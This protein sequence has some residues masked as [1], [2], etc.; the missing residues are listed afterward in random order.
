MVS[1]KVPLTTVCWHEFSLTLHPDLYI[2]IYIWGQVKIGGPEQAPGPHP[3]HTPVPYPRSIP[4]WRIRSI[5]LFQ[6]SDPYVIIYILYKYVYI[7]DLI[8]YI[9]NLCIYIILYVYIYMNMCN[10]ILHFCAHTAQDLWLCWEVCA[11]ST[12]NCYLLCCVMV[13]MRLA[14]AGWQSTLAPICQFW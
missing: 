1:A 9:Y 4:P 6:T 14:A 12:Y 2:Y 3:F 8:M 10:L 5:P 7:Y 11:C 13:G